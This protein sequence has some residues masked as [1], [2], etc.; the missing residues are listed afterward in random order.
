M[1]LVLV[2]YPHISTDT[3]LSLPIS[4]QIWTIWKPHAFTLK[5]APNNLNKSKGRSCHTWLTVD[6][7]TFSQLRGNEP[8][9][10]ALLLVVAPTCVSLCSEVSW[11]YIASLICGKRRPF[12]ERRIIS[13]TLNVTP[14]CGWVT[15]LAV[16]QSKYLS[17][18]IKILC[19]VSE[20]Q[21][22]LWFSV[23]ESK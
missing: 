17:G 23:S 3:D 18:Q 1:H 12:T 4:V 15:V 6:C 16:N 10:E 9:L 2:C 19:H 21:L 14:S 8:N 5:M 20:Q 7:L 22:F 13:H 11:P